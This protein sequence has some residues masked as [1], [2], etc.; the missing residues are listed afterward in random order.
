MSK[1]SREV[2]K[3]EAILYELLRLLGQGDRPEAASALVRAAVLDRPD[4][5]NWHRQI[6]NYRLFKR[7]PPDE[8]NKLITT[9]ADHVVGSDP[10]WEASDSKPVNFA[11]PLSAKPYVKITTFKMLADI[12]ACSDAF[13]VP[14]AIS[15]KR[16]L[17]VQSHLD[18]RVMALKAVLELLAS[19]P[20]IELTVEIKREVEALLML[21]V[22][23]LG[24]L[25]E[26]DGPQPEMKSTSYI[27]RELPTVDSEA[28]LFRTINWY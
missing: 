16:I 7:L 27:D 2:V 6:F 11:V 4:S 25:S 8:A 22:P 15:L 21:L 12:L 14:I 26:R 20:D 10:P 3:P 24:S 5:S 28:L 9:F 13:S 18:V 23:M 1:D 19:T 17:L